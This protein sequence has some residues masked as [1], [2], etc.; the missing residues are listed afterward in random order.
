MSTSAGPAGKGPLGALAGVPGLTGALAQAA[1]A[2]LVQSTG[3][4]LLAAGLAHAIARATG[5]ADGGIGTPLA[6]AAAGAVLRALAGT[7]GEVLAARDARRAEDRL[8]RDLLDRLTASPR[9]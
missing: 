6:L 9:R 5:N 1:A 8:R 4:V 3:L 2:A 7:V